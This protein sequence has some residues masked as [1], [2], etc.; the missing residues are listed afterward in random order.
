MGFVR[1]D[2][3][4]SPVEIRGFSS[5]SM[6]TYSDYAVVA[7]DASHK[8]IAFGKEA[9]QYKDAVERNEIGDSNLVY[10]GR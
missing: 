9:Y 10:Y 5:K 2:G 8:I 3:D 4:F 7:L 6:K 1:L